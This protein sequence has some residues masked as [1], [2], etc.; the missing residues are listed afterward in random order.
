MN[1]WT[2]STPMRAILLVLI[3]VQLG[4]C[5]TTQHVQLAANPS[6]TEISGVTLKTGRTIVFE[7]KG[8]VISRD[9]IYAQTA[10]GQVVIPSE[11]VQD[12]WVKHFSTSRTIGLIAG[13]A[14]VLFG[15]IELANHTAGHCN[16]CQ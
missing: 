9:T 16:A 4:A 6:P 1:G 3:A 8:A 5:T 10:E 13:T 14:V 7:P 11:S 12:V 15:F 2:R